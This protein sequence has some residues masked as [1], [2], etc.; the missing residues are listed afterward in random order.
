MTETRTL[1]A[2]SVPDRFA[3]GWHCLGL[4][5]DFNDGKPHEV[6][7]FGGKLV[8]WADS[9]GKL[10]VLDGYCRHMGGD[11]TQGT[12]KGDEI[13]CP[14]HDW[15]WGGDGKCKAIP[16]AKRVPLRARTQRYEAVVRN[17]QLLIWHDPEHSE[18]DM[19]ALPPELPGVGTD[20]YS[21]WTWEILPVENAHCR[22]IIDNVVDM[23]H[24]FY[25]HFAFPTNFRNVFEG[26][27]ATQFMES[28]GRPDM[29]AEGYGDEDLVLKS[30]A[31]YFG[32][33]YMINWLDTDYN[34][35]LTKVILINCH[36]PT[37]P[38]SFNLQYG[39]CVEKPEGVD[40]ATAK[41][42]GDKYAESF[43]VG[44][45]QDVAIWL[46]KAPVQNPLL[47]EEDGPVYQLRRWYEQ[48]YVDK[49][50]I[51]PEM[52]ERFEFEVDT[53]KANENWRAEVAEN[54]AR[55]EAEDREAEKA[56]A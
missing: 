51:E 38:N 25:I 12:V 35:F 6:Q 27:Q 39:L 43:K 16:Y 14:F 26:D 50:D 4:E 29:K 11:L 17:G 28:T 23:A 42:I 18:A 7:A 37:G 2:G 13:A 1:D 3:R 19:D 55:K 10:N 45:E 30:V 48:F 47:C 15:R 31:T 44:F 24:F 5:R 54:L 53:T 21:D 32:P 36:V 9:Q 52:V 33:S 22:E 8:V 56:D 34:G 40:E 49:A 20:K 46:N 41:Y